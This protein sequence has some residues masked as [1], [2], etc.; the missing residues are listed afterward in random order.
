MARVRFSQ[1]RKFKLITGEHLPALQAKIKK[2]NENG[3]GEQVELCE[4]ITLGLYLL[5]TYPNPMDGHKEFLRLMK[6]HEERE[7]ITDNL[8]MNELAKDLL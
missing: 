2:A 7:A 4:I 6:N 5:E 1:F 8:D 3:T